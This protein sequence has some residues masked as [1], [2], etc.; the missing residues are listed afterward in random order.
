MILMLQFLIT[1]TIAMLVYEGGNNL[2]PRAESYE[3]ARNT[4]SELGRVYAFTGEEKPLSRWLFTAAMVLS[5]TGLVLAH[6]AF[7]WLFRETRPGGRPLAASAAIIGSIVGLG[8]VGIG[9]F[10]TDVRTDAHYIAVYFAF[11][12]M[13]P[14]VL[15]TLAA[16]FRHPRAPLLSRVIHGAFSAVLLAYLYLIWFGPPL[17]SPDGLLLQVIGQKLIVYLGILGM[18][19]QTA[20]ALRRLNAQIRRPD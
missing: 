2:N 17:A 7:P 1:T 4:F 5:G 16:L 11:T 18:T 9:I 13:L 6:A 15:A 19:A 3:F 20:I 10:P 12:G 14:A 8:F